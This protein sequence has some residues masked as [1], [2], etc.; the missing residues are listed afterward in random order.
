MK[1]KYNVYFVL[2]EQDVLCE[3]NQAAFSHLTMAIKQNPH[4]LDFF[5]HGKEQIYAAVL[6]L[7]W[8][9]FTGYASFHSYQLNPFKERPLES[10]GFF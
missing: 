3:E 8:S 7:S 9:E 1:Q 4:F 2:K 6:C 10:A 5:P